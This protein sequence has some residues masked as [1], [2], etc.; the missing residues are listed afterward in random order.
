MFATARPILLSFFGLPRMTHS[1]AGSA[2][3]HRSVLLKL[4]LL[5]VRVV[6]E[7]A[8]QR[9][10]PAFPNGEP[11]ANMRFNLDDRDLLH[12]VYLLSSLGDVQL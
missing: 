8:G 7:H 5:S 3:V 9:E 6:R 10:S 2:V 1:R 4:V 11:D 12:L